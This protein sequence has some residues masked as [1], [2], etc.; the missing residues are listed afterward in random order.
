MDIEKGAGHDALISE[1][2][3]KAQIQPRQLKVG[4]VLH[5]LSGFAYDD[6]TVTT[7]WEEW[8]VTSIR[9]KPR[10]AID[11]ILQRAG[12]EL[13][14]PIKTVHLTQKISDITWIKSGWKKHISQRYREFFVHGGRLP[15]GIYTT[16]NKAAQYAKID[17]ERSVKWYEAELATANDADRATYEEETEEAK[18]ILRAIKS[19]TTKLKKSTGA[20]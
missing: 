12:V 19:R 14:P 16:Q 13:S 18:R 9:A 3:M 10:D 6:G 17:A 4:A 11:R 15:R 5:R 7:E 2:P 20:A 1:H 8:H